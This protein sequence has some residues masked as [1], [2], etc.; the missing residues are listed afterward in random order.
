MAERHNP[1]G[2]DLLF[3]SSKGGPLIAVRDSGTRTDLTSEGFKRTAKLAGVYR[4]RMGLY[5]FRHTFQTIG[6][7]VGDPV[8]TSSLM[9]H[10]D[11]SMSAVY[12]EKIGEDRL[13]KVTHHVRSWLIPQ[14]PSVRH[15]C[16]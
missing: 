12:R 7:E 3:L 13:L 8:A 9:G 16:L 11:G 1:R 10:A 4:P 15:R 2:L 6:D 14:S 5:W